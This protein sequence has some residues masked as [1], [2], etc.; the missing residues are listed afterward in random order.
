MN[1]TQNHWSI[2]VGGRTETEMRATAQKALADFLGWV[3]D[4]DD[5]S[6][7]VTE[8]RWVVGQPSPSYYLGVASFTWFGEDPDTRPPE[9]ETT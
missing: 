7:D 9:P 2:E 8:N 4:P 5:I 6:I 3:V 1:L